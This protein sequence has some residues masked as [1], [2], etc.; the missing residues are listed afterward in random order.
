ME[1]M[2]RK[3]IALCLDLSRAS[4]LGFIVSLLFWY[5]PAY[6]FECF[7]FYWC[8][9]FGLKSVL[10]KLKYFEESFVSR[11]RADVSARSVGMVKIQAILNIMLLRHSELLY[12]VVK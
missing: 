5:I 11:R 1:E 6:G 12:R 8:T 3:F 10:I 2:D 4:Q 9:G 7:S